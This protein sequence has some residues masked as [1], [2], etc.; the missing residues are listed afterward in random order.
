[1]SARARRAIAWL[2]CA[3]L[4]WCG[5][6]HAGPPLIT[7]DPG[8][9]GP[10]AWEINLAATG[11]RVAG[12]WDLDA[13]DLDLNRGVGDSVQLS[14]HVPWAH[15]RDDGAGWSSGLGAAEFALRWRFLDQERGG[16]S[17]AVQPTWVSSFSRAARRRGLASEHAEFVLPL[18]VGRESA[19]QAW[20]VEIA[21]HFVQ[22]EADAWQAGAFVGHS[23]AA[24]LQC[25]VELNTTWAPAP[26]TVFDLGVVQDRGRH[27]KLL[28]SLGH[29][30][31][32]T[33]GE[34]ARA[35]FYLGAQLLY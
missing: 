8:T 32:G 26:A 14:L 25:L 21:R 35:V 10:G 19:S 15:R 5:L 34:R 9:P 11:A 20:G 28:G 33:A 17:V 31:G 13:P 6:A 27:L 7:N 24:R 4:G 16:V 22:G 23:C 30:F 3:W 18:Q 2:A 1:M 12:A 29:Q